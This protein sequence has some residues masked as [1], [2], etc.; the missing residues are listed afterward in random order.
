MARRH[1]NGTWLVRGNQSFALGGSPNPNPNE[2]W[3]GPYPLFDAEHATIEWVR[4]SAAT[5]TDIGEQ[6]GAGVTTTFELVYTSVPRA[7]LLDPRYP[8][9]LNPNLPYWHAVAA[10][11]QFATIPTLISTDESDFVQVSDN[12]WSHFMLRMVVSATVS[13]LYVS[14]NYFSS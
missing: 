12:G 4:Y 9:R 2:Y 10:P 1:S 7:W 5:A 6:A 11:A 8:K 13:G 3:L 14:L